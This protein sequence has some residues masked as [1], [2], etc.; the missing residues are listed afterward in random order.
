M[1]KSIQL[2]GMWSSFHISRI[3]GS[4]ASAEGGCDPGMIS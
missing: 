1:N 4:H 2:L 3:I